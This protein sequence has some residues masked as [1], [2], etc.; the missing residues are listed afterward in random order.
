L[1]RWRHP[2]RG[3]VPPDN[4]IPLAE[5]IR[6]ISCLCERVLRTACAEAIRWPG[7]MTVEVNVAAQQFESGRLVGIVEA[8]LQAAGLP[9]SRLELEITESALLN[10]PGVLDD[11]RRPRSCFTDDS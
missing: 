4:F 1:L 9:G 2:L 11:E 3:L 6:L 10:D 5:D 8:A 7:A